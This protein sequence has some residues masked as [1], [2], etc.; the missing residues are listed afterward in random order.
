MLANLPSF[1]ASSHFP[2][3]KKAWEV[4][5]T[6]SF[7]HDVACDLKVINICDLSDQELNQA[8]EGEFPNLAIEFPSNTVLPINFYLKG[9]LLTLI[10]QQKNFGQVRVMQTF[11]V[12]CVDRQLI[13]S[14][15]LSD[16]K[17]FL[18]FITGQISVALSIQDKQPSIVFESETNRRS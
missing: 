1:A 7:D 10:D 16:W 6:Y 11:Y 2:K 12:R 5:A 4:R 13:L 8:M 18:E 9:D 14:S 15:D 17:P 3:N